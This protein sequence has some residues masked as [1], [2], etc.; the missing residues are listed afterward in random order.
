MATNTTTAR[1]VFV[2]GK[3]IAGNRQ[4][5]IVESGEEYSVSVSTIIAYT[6]QT[7]RFPYDL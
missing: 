5:L 6:D 4:A 3:Q 7:A 1:T 2:L